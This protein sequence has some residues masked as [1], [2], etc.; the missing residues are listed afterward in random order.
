MAPQ[1]NAFEKSSSPKFAS[2][3][4]SKGLLVKNKEKEI[5]RQ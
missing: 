4:K 5:K 2:P 1:Y 3:R